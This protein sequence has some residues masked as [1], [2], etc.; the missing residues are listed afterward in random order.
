MTASG[1]SALH[2]RVVA[3]IPR[4][5][6][7]MRRRISQH[8]RLPTTGWRLLVRLVDLADSPDRPQTQAELAAELCIS[9]SSFTRLVDRMAREGLVRRVQGP[10]RRAHR[11]EVRPRGAAEW[12]RLKQVVQAEFARAFAGIPKHDL[13]VADRVLG[14]IRAHLESQA[15]EKK[16]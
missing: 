16:P 9:P 3:A 14:M 13:R 7:L 1:D 11:I 10:S 6:R 5:T 8:T 12:R 4:I 15:K 2:G